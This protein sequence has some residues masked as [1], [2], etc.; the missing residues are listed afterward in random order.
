MIFSSVAYAMIIVSAG[1]QLQ[2]T[3]IYGHMEEWLAARSFTGKM[4]ATSKQSD[5]CLDCGGGVCSLLPPSGSGFPCY[6]G[7]NKD[8]NKCYNTV[9]LLIVSCPLPY[10]YRIL[11]CLQV[12]LQFVAYVLILVTLRIFKTILFTKTWNSGEKRRE[13]MK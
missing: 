13:T 7:A 11:C 5:A 6:Q 12:L 3:P 4:G 2:N 1:A 10:I 9:G 8:A